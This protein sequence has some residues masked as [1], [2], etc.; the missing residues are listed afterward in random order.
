MIKEALKPEANLSFQEFK[1]EDRWLKRKEQTVLD[2]GHCSYYVYLQMKK[3]GSIGN[4]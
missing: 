4:G 3:A 2:S 1:H